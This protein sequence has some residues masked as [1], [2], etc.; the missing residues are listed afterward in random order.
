MAPTCFAFPGDLCIRQQPPS[1]LAR[2]VS[3]EEREAKSKDGALG[4]RG[5]IAVHLVAHE[6]IRSFS[7]VFFFFF[8]FF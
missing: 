1:R 2:V 4:S 7:K 6:N 3:R 8:F 5:K